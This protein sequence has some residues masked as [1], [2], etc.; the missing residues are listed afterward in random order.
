MITVFGSIN[1]DQVGTV[2]RLPRPG[3]TVAGGTFSTASGGKGANQALAARRAGATVRQVGAVGDDAF[4]GE[5]LILLREAGV[6]LD[7][8][9]VIENCATG[10]AMIFVDAQGEN[11]IA[12]LPGANGQVTEDEAETAVSGMKAGDVLLLQQEVPHQATLH[13]LRL[14]REKG[15]IS[16]LNTAP[17]LDTTVEAAALAD[18]VVAN[19]T[20]F[21]LLAGSDEATRDSALAERSADTGRTFIVTLGAAGAVAAKDGQLIKAPAPK[22]TPLDTVGAGDTFCGYLGAGL[23][24]GETLEAAMRLAIAAA[25][26]A[27]LKQGAQPAIPSRSDV[28]AVLA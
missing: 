27:C 2:P 7:G 13:A 19:E 3:E 20:E 9:R 14:A 12:V 15:V 22:I 28:E 25:S 26:L 5:A 21:D 17:F 8:V 10:I 16:I 24:A 11:V 4:A 23:E 18:I 1:L 6:D